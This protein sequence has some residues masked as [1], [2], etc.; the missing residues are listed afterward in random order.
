MKQTYLIILVLFNILPTPIK[1]NNNLINPIKSSK[2]CTA[3][4]QTKLFRESPV[5]KTVRKL[6]YNKEIR[7]NHK[8]ND[9]IFLQLFAPSKLAHYFENKE[10]QLFHY[11]S[12]KKGLL[13]SKETRFKKSS[14]NIKFNE[15]EK[16]LEEYFISDKNILW[17][18]SLNYSYR[19]YKDGVSHTFQLKIQFIDFIYSGPKLNLLKKLLPKNL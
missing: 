17:P 2:Y 1:A 14:L 18:K 7:L 5:F 6:I 19:F 12:F 16:V 10:I 11:P 9:K 4:Y 8:L 15:N 3:I 13:N